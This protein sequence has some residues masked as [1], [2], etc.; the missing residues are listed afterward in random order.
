[1]Y[2]VIQVLLLIY[3]LYQPYPI[4]KLKKGDKVIVPALSWSTTIFPSAIR[5]ITFCDCNDLDF[6]ISIDNF[7][8]CRNP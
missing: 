1:M 2:F 5:L 4:K 3:L 8:D 7:N 6:N